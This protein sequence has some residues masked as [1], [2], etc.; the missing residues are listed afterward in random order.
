MGEG[1][2]YGGGGEDERMRE[3]GRGNIEIE[4]EGRE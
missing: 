3:K 1:G 2:R 4:R